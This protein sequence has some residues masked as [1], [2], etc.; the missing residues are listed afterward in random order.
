MNTVEIQ[1]DHSGLTITEALIRSLEDAVRYNPNDAVRPCAILWTDQEAQWQPIIPL[2]RQLLPHL[3]TLGEYQPD[4]RTGP[5]IWL[6][7][8]VDRALPNIEWLEENPPIL[9]LP[10]VSRQ[11]LRAVQECPDNL[12]PLVELQY[13]GVCWTQKNGKDW[14]VEAFLVSEDGGLGLYLARDDATRQAMLGALEELATTAVEH[15]TGKHLEAEDF[16]R[17]FS[18][19]IVRDLLRWL[20]EPETVK[21]QWSDSRWSAFKSCCQDDYKFDPDRDGRVGRC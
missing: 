16:N 10:Y 13:R 12:K 5:A 4:Q 21:S 20:N 7:S 2:L 15:L 17:L 11:K 1:A 9:Y 3:L 14:T 6:R 19:D 8:A 18:D